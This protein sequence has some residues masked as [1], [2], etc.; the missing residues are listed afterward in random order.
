MEEV[1]V[2]SPC[3]GVGA[4]LGGDGGTG[5]AI[6][7]GTRDRVLRGIAGG[8]GDGARGAIVGG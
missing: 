6:L 7:D 1:M 4:T 2:F 5:G 8:V 3:V